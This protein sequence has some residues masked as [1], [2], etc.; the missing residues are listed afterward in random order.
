M[1]NNTVNFYN[2]GFTLIELLVVIA[3]IGILAS[4]ILASLT[5]ARSK[6]RDAR[7]K[8]DLSQMVRANE[9]YRND[10][11]NYPATAGWFHNA[12]HGGLDA[13]LVPGYISKISDDPIISGSQNYMYYR[14]DYATCSPTL[15]ID[16]YSYYAKLENPST[17]D[18]ATVSDSYDTCIKGLYGMNYRVGN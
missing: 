1:K 2:K 12:G 16:K 6:A 11:S 14:K 3:I 10:N 13:A 7:R 5:S 17:A 18:L 9:L 15:G 8:S 4:V